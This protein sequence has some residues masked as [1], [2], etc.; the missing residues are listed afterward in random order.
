MLQIII[1]FFIFQ[2][3][4]KWRRKLWTPNRGT[5]SVHEKDGLQ[6]LNT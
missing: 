4:R 6:Y 5:Q 2:H 1:E 3:H